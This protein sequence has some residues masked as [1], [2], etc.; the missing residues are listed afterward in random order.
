M[1][2]ITTDDCKNFLVSQFPETTSKSWKRTKK[3]RDEQG[4][5][6]RI[7][8]NDEKQV[9]V[10]ETAGNLS[11]L[12]QQET[13]KKVL[14]YKA[15]NNEQKAKALELMD[16]YIDNFPRGP[17]PSPSREGFEAIP[18]LISFYF[19]YYGENEK[20][21]PTNAINFDENEFT[22]MMMVTNNEFD[23]TLED[24]I[25]PLIP[26]YFSEEGE[27]MFIVDK[28]KDL[29]G[30]MTYMDLI[31]ELMNRGFVYFPCWS[32]AFHEYFKGYTIEGKKQD[33]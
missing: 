13:P 8:E 16:E 18:N 27:G 15:F 9:F 31:Q 10:L 1:P 29:K 3:Y 14:Y 19:E 23:Q 25:S 20:A 28:P 26:S 21:R 11:L 2:K 33:D 12:D 30:K 24:L 5:W 7:F 17:F 22:L 32:C 4:N 6:V